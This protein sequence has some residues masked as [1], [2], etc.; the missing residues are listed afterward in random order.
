M[1]GVSCSVQ[2]CG[3]GGGEADAAQDAADGYVYD[4]AGLLD[5]R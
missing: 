1:P 5:G 4:A 2:R 3:T